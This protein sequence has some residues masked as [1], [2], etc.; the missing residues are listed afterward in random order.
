MI[1]FDESSEGGGAAGSV[2]LRPTDGSPAM[3]L[4]DGI[5]RAI[6]PD[7]SSVLVSRYGSSQFGGLH[8]LPTGVGE[9][10][11]IPLGDRFTQN[12]A[13]LPDARHIVVAANENKAG[14]R[15]YLVDSMTGEHLAISPEGIDHADS[16]LLPH[17]DAI[18]AHN[19][20]QGFQLYPI[21]GGE[22][23][24]VPFL[25]T[26]DRVIRWARDG[27]AVFIHRPSEF[28]GKIYRLDL[29]SG[30]RSIVREL[31]P[32]DPTGI[33]RIARVH[34]SEDTQSYAYSYYM[35]L[36]DLHVIEGLR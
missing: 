26:Q 6:S 30:E 7:G 18:L 16:H 20:E 13:Y 15:L 1:L 2:Y 5:G 29:D 34:L 10:R 27:N 32:T 35:Q 19:S 9:P 21:R 31:M 36:L 3:R 28:P 23:Q 8:L 12:A 14:V 17:G 25:S 11:D 22:P 24:S 4:G 33:Y